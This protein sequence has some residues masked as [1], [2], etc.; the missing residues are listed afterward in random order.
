[1]RYNITKALLL[2]VVLLMLLTLLACTIPGLEGNLLSREPAGP[3]VAISSP[4]GR[5]PLAM[6]R[7]IKVES[8][9]IDSAGVTRVELVVNGEVIWIDANAKPEPDT[10]FIVAQ[11]WTPTAPGRYVIQVRSYNQAA[12]VGESAPLTVEVVAQPPLAST[13][14]ATPGGPD[15]VILAA[16]P[17]ATL[18]PANTVSARPT[19][20]L[21]STPAKPSPSPTLTKTPTTTPQPRVFDPTGLEPDGRFREIWLELGS[22]NSRLGYPTSAEIGDRNYAR[23]F[24][25]TGL[26]FW[27]DSPETADVIWVLDSPA[28]DFSSGATSNR[29]VDTWAGGDEYS[30][31]EARQG[32]PVRG[33]G[34][35]WC[36]R[37]ELQAR[38][39]FPS[40]PE[41]G[42]AGRP[43]YARVQRFQGGT[44][45]YNPA[46]SQVYVIFAQG[47]WLGFDY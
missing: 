14:T 19:A 17:T 12:A 46:N 24:F 25:E 43:P 27:W 35:L 18:A 9:S 29:Y 23:Q 26:M 15:I 11:P 10:P 37:A 34:K 16:T 36:D 3:D 42:S 1:M 47:D 38:L 5:Q 6:D 41:S 2:T 39:G 40:E 13:S 8:V 44:M 33:F 45:I 31:D 22:S 21:T 20:S 7:E 28:V 4:T 30:C 32:G